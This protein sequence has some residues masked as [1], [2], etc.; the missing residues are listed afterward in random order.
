[1]SVLEPLVI[2]HPPNLYAEEEGVAFNV[3]SMPSHAL[4][5]LVENV[6][7]VTVPAGLPAM[8]STTRGQVVTKGLF[9]QLDYF[10]SICGIISLEFHV[11]VVISY[12]LP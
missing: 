8:R 3:T 10:I 6:P 5:T 7:P 9:V 2:V 4:A 11:G 1:M 12:Q